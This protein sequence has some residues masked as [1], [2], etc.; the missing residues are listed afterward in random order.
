MFFKKRTNTP[1]SDFIRNASSE[2]KKK[3]YTRV[4]KRAAEQQRSLIDEVERSSDR[5]ATDA[6]CPA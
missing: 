1:F 6:S 2:K 3:V 5:D 4:M